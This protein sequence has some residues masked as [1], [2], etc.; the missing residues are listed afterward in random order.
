MSA[1]IQNEPAHHSQEQSEA[2]V[3]ESR[4]THVRFQPGEN[5]D[6]ANGDGESTAD[7]YRNHP[8]REKGTSDVYN[9][10]T[11]RTE[12]DQDGIAATKA[13]YLPQRRKARQQRKSEIRISKSETN[14]RADKSQMGKIQNTESQGSSF[15]G[16][17][18][19]G[20]LNLF[21]ISDFELRILNLYLAPLAILA[22][23]I[24]E[25]FAPKNLRKPLKL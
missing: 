6:I 7:K 19:F 14:V 25:N 5:E 18:K 24:S 22:R 13:D 21:R 11:T 1:P 17:P 8:A 4:R 3:D 2:R 16:F 9:G 23:V 20:H 12:E 10:I 15:G